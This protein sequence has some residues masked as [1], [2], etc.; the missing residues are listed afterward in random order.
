MN[1][2]GNN[3]LITGGAG[4]I[5]SHLCEF[6]LNRGNNV[7]C[8]DNLVTGSYKNIEKL[9]S[10]TKF[11]FVKQDVQ[12]SFDFEVELI[13]NLACPAS[14]KHYQATPIETLKTNFIGAMNT[15]DLAKKNNSRIVQAS[16]SE[17]YGDP[18]ISP[19]VESYNGN[20]NTLG[21]RACYDEGK[22]VV[23]SIFM[24][25]HRIHDVDIRIARIFNTYGPQ[26]LEDDGRVV[27]NF[28]V[29][30]LRDEDITIYGDGSQTRSLCYIDD[31]I[32]GL[33]LMAMSSNFSGPINLGNPRS[34]SINNL[35]SLIVK[36][37][38]SKSKISFGSL[39]EDDPQ[40]REPN[41]NEAKKLL[42]WEP[43]ITLEQGL[44]STIAY[45]SNLI[46]K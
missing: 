15:L 22:R 14:P 41:I 38:K 30:A 31:L 8:L 33:C 20:V 39:P 7:I 18:K 43:K 1:L 10:N 26:M 2:R 40:F 17:I 9:L 45:F 4:F 44:L 6:L 19:Q 35:A 29:Q 42:G 25:Y 28:I 5:G 16:T 3:I 13:F 36:M 12:K 34:I 37:T 23:E 32:N 11:K 46:S 21:I 27:S 24:E